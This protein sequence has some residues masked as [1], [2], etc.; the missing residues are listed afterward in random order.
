MDPDPG[1]PKKRGSGFGSA[2]LEESFENIK[3]FEAGVGPLL[4]HM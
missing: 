3:L 1:G 2:T 4:L